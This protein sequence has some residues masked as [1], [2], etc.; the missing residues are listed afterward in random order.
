MSQSLQVL[1][2]HSERQRDDGLLQVQKAQTQLR[3]QEQ[4]AEQLLAYRAEYQAR[5]PALNGRS[6]S[7]DMLRYHQSFMDRLN[8]AV[9]QQQQ[10]VQAAHTRWVA[11]QNEQLALEMRVASVRKLMQRRDHAQEQISHRKDQRHTD[12]MAA[13]VVRRQLEQALQESAAGPGQHA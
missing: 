11:R 4:Q 1:M 9:Q 12:E 6:S 3:Q 2:A 10:Q 13:G 8:Q 5:H 7:I